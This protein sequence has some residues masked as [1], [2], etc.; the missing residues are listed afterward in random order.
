MTQW[1]E[2]GKIY[3]QI[4]LTEDISL[5][6]LF[7]HDFALRRALLPLEGAVAVEPPGAHGVADAVQDAQAQHA[8]PHAALVAAAPI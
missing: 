6:L 5:T 1:S 3:Q 8:P 4:S 2:T 7:S